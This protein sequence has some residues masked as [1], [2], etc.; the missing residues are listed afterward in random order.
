MAKINGL[1][2]MTYA[3]LAELR[4]RV[5]AAMEAA[6]AAEK[7]KLRTEMEAMAVKAGLSLSEVV[8]RRDRR[9]KATGS[10]VAP[11]YR[12]PQ[13]PEETW[14]GRGRQPRWVV[15]ALKRGRK[16]ESFLI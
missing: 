12:N 4:G 14:A 9:P 5:D 2:K 16:L 6:K 13:N 7:G 10:K 1:E 3:Q 8:G 15:A 11:K